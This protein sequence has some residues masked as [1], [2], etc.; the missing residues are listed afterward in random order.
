MQI[1][2]AI[3]HVFGTIFLTRWKKKQSI[4]INVWRIKNTLLVIFVWENKEFPH[5]VAA[6]GS[7]SVVNRNILV[8]NFFQHHRQHHDVI[9]RRILQQI[10]L[11]PPQRNSINSIPKIKSKNQKKIEKK[12]KRENN[13]TWLRTTLVSRMR[14]V[15]ADGLN[16]AVEESHTLQIDAPQ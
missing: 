3:Q 10:N 11:K 2:S 6:K 5:R 4:G 7:K 8:L 1:G 16:R 12:R 13:F 14:I 15:E 9:N